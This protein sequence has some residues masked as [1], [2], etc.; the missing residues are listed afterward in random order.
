MVHELVFSMV[1]LRGLA[2]AAHITQ[3]RP[4]SARVNLEPHDDPG[5]VNR[6]SSRISLLP[7]S[8][9]AAN[10]L[11]NSPTLVNAIVDLVDDDS[12][13]DTVSIPSTDDDLQDE[14]SLGAAIV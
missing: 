13:I 12:E 11:A 9:E 2:H 10:R 4:Q 7:K 3:G 5:P 8:Q 6:S 1:S 14:F